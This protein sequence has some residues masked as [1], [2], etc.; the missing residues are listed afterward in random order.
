MMMRWFQ[1]SVLKFLVNVGKYSSPMEHFGYGYLLLQRS[2]VTC[3]RRFWNFLELTSE[4]FKF[5]I[6]CIGRL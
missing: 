5:G 2:V 3:C 4:V 1:F 6:Q